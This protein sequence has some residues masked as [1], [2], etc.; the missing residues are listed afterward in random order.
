MENPNVLSNFNY[1]HNRNYNSNQTRTLTKID[2]FYETYLKTG[3]HLGR[4]DNMGLP[5]RFKILFMLSS[6]NKC[7]FT[8]KREIV[9]RTSIQML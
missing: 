9:I 3:S 2:S 5:N 4:T 7:K 6:E 1:S 8:T